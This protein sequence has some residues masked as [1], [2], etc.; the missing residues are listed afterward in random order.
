MCKRDIPRKLQNERFPKIDDPFRLLTKT[1][2]LDKVTKARGEL[3]I[4]R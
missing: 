4:D 3:K 1:I 2:L